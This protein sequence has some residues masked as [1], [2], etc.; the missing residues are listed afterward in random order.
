CLNS[1]M[2]ESTSVLKKHALAI[3]QA[4]L[5]AVRPE[6]LIR[7]AIAD[8]TLGL[9]REIERCRRILVVGAGKA[10]AAMSAAV[11]TTLSNSLDRVE[12][13]VNVPTDVVRPLNRVHLHG[14]R[15]RGVNQP[16]ADGVAGADK[17]LEIVNSAGPDDLILC[18]LSGGGS[19]L[20][21]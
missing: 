9:D 16:T 8:S 19:A 3:W 5:E 6:K 18:L 15:R 1:P 11:E 7:A 20:L 17:I 4:A 21:P 14:A 2:S 12:G 10:G 13:W